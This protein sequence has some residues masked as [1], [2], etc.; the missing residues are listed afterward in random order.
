MSPPSSLFAFG[1]ANLSMLGWLAV[2]TAPI[3]IH[4]WNRRRYRET[5]WAAME[6]LLAAAERRTRRLRF[7][8]WL[9]LAVRTLLIV[10][11]VLAVAEPYFERPGLAIGSEGHSH[12][13]LVLDD[14]YSMAYRPT[15]KTRFERAKELAR[16]MIEESPQGDAFTLVVM[17][18]SPRAVVAKPALERNEMAQEIDNLEISNTKADLPA[19]VAAVRRIVD[20]AQRENARLTRHEV[21]FL[22]DLQR[23]TWAPKLS[24]PAAANLLR[25]T[26]ELSRRA[27][28]FVIDLGQPRV[29]NL[30]VT[31]LRADDP[32]MVVGRDV[33]LAAELRNYGRQML[34][35]QPVELLVD[36]RRIEQKEVD[37]GADATASVTFSYRFDAPMDHAVEVRA[38]GDALEVDN[39]RYLAAPVRQA[40]R[41]LCIDGRPSGIPFRGAADYLA[42]AL[43]PQDTPTDHAL[44][45][46]EVATENALM[47]RNLGA[48]DCVF[49]CNVAQFTGSEARV[50]E[51]YLQSG[52][53][54]V[55]FLGDRVLADAY[56]REL[57]PAAEGRA[58]RS[59]ILHARLGPVVD[60]P[61]FRLDPLGY[62]HPIVEPFRGPGETSL[63]TTPVLKY[64]KLTIPKNSRVKTVLALADGDP[65]IVEEPI[66][67]GRVVLVAT[68][69]E[70]S[71]T[72]M[73]LWPSFVPLVQEIV[74]WCVEGR[75]RQRN[76]LVGEPLE[77]A[78]DPTAADAPSSVQTPDGHS[79]RVQ[80]RTTGD[81]S[82]LSYTRT[83][84]NGMYAMR[85][86][87]PLNRN[88]LFAVNVD[89]IESDLAT[90]DPEELRKRVW[91][92]IP[93]I[94]QTSW[95]D[96]DAAGLADPTRGGRLHIGLL[97]AA[98]GLLFVEVFLGWKMGYHEK[99]LGIG[100]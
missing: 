11:V 17:A 73:P 68:S 13:V 98:L 42:V 58:G 78:V 30:A 56:N 26:E 36:R 71:W 74:A 12:R 33:R 63:L 61:Q 32:L 50:L 84:K 1:W 35:G 8:Q 93:F 39:G 70:P 100:D 3:L 22:T 59:H 91:P 31:D 55:F 60:R 34:S 89:T 29:E 69:A 16:R 53:N 72:A 57:G 45:R 43:A 54:L 62:R 2:A 90:I 88:E 66:H 77:V 41:A 7:E 28:L 10:F 21:Y 64:Y 44:I 14:S 19:T 52:G 5:S 79:H 76:L 85:F 81:D 96:L 23:V 48:Y 9:L 24:K 80:V 82:T 49:L 67:R 46:V 95:Q 40:I 87:P 65:L 15:D 37:I 20:N 86:G 38:A 27:M 4:L 6:Y 25:Q 94:H 51:G 18:S 47:D 97:Y 99:G 83:A 75:L 92:G